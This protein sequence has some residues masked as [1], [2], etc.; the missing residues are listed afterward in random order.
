MSN[1]L[2]HLHWPTVAS[3]FR[4]RLP[5]QLFIF[6]LLWW[7]SVQVA[8][9]QPANDNP[10]GAVN[11]T[12]GAACTPTTGTNVAATTTTP[13]GYTNPGFCGAAA[14]PKDVW[15]RFTATTSAVRITVTGAPAG[16]VRLFSS[17]AGAAGPFTELD[18]NDGGTNNAVADAFTTAGLTVG[19]TY[20]VA[21]SGFGSNDTQGSFTICVTGPSNCAAAVTGAAFNTT[22]NIASFNAATGATGYSIF[23]SNSTTLVASGTITGTS[24]NLSSF[25]T[26]GTPYSLVVYTVCSNGGIS[27]PTTLN[28][29][30][31]GTSGT[32][33]AV[34]GASVGNI[35][36]NAALLTYTAAAG[37]TNYTITLS[38]GTGA[39][40]SGTLTGTSI[41]LTSLS[42]STQYTVTVV[43]NCSNG[44]T[45]SPVTV[46]F[47]TAAASPAPA[48]D[49]CAGAVLLTPSATCSPVNGTIAGATQ[50]LAAI[51]CGGSTTTAAVKDVWYRF[52]AT[53]ASHTV[54]IAGTFDG[55]LDVRTG[56][57][58]SSTNLDCADAVGNNETLTLTN[59]TPGTTYFLRYYPYD[60]APAG[61][62]FTI[63]VTTP[64]TAVCAD[65]TAGIGNVTNTTAQLLVTPGTGNTSYI[66]TYTPTGGSTTTLNPNPTTSP[67]NLVGLSPGT[68]YALTIQSVCANGSLGAILTGSFTTQTVAPPA[69]DNP[70]GAFSLPVTA[71]CTP[72]AGTNAGATTTT[73]NGF[74]NP[75]TCGVASAPR[76]VWYTFV[77]PNTSVGITVTGAPAGLVRVF[78]S[79]G[80]A[81][82]PFTQVS[83]GAGTTNN[84]SAG[85]FTVAGLTAGATYYVSV[86]GY[87]SNDTQ[88]AFT[89]CVTG[90]APAPTCNPVTGLSVNDI[91]TTTARVS[92][93]PG[94]G[95]TSYTI[96]YTPANGTATTVTSSTPSVN[97]STLTPGTVYTVSV[98]PI[99]AGG[100]TATATTTTFT[101]STPPCEPVS[102][103]TVSGTT[104]TTASVSFTPG[105]G[106]TS[107]TVTY[108]PQGGPTTTISPAPTA[109]P[110]PLSGLTP[111]TLYTVSV[112]PICAGGG[113]TIATTTTFTTTAAPATCNPVTNLAVGGITTTAA[114]VSFTPGTG[115]TSYTVTY[116]PA[117]GATTIIS[118][119]PT[120]SPV[121]LSNLTPG[122]LYTVSV[123]PICAGGG[124]AAAVTT[125]FTTLTPTCNPVTNLAVGGITTTTASVSFTPGTGN[126]S[127]T[128]TYTPAGGATT[129]ISPAPTGSPVA[130]SSLTP[131]TV[132]TV[133]VTPI[134]AGG[135]TATAVTTTFTT[136]AAPVCEPVTALAVGNITTTGAA[137]TFVPGTGNTGYTVTYTSPNGTAVTVNP[138]P[139]SSPVALTGLTPNTPYTVTVT[140][141]CAG[142]GTAATVTTTFTTLAPACDPVT[143]LT[144]TVLGST[145]ANL[146]FTAA[147]G[148]TS[149]TVTYTPAGG[150]AT[151]VT[152]TASPVA[153]AGLTP[154][155]SYTAT[156]TTTCGATQS[157]AA[158]VTFTTQP[159]ATRSALESQVQVFPNPAQRHFT[160]QVPTVTG[161]TTLSL[162]LYNSLGQLVRQQQV[163]LKANGTQADVDVSQLAAGVYTLRLQA[164][165]ELI[166]KRVTVATN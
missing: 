125:T 36:S 134:C 27:Q 139:T 2:L 10:A 129:T 11:L 132:Y 144:A 59:L 140:P 121:A 70:A 103:L 126:T 145:S 25:V 83:C 18:C 137:V 90:S 6:F 75:G 23:L 128:V 101:T 113:T 111:G 48:N 141:I 102:G 66:V 20:Y 68:T 97:L 44:G 159:L 94:T 143:N 13:N 92:F 37:A 82:G 153:L 119:A 106:N 71:T 14:N 130:L 47:T 107:Y 69:N 35:S 58:A 32:C 142:G 95:N 89:I 85:S 29:T 93:T 158:S 16:L 51:A 65:P 108:T 39:P 49:N 55:V 52:V 87:G 133:S 149:Y 98:T 43:T 124:T 64:T 157:S 31:A 116:T 41:S 42:P 56:T 91:F 84:T 53:A 73:P 99:C 163:S 24:V 155:T 4:G 138:T 104:T 136:T 15:Y 88:G 74:T 33:A 118:P 100:G 61:S 67:I 146:T 17:T 34:T 8:F 62:T 156:V 38:S 26:A 1:T 148:A 76:D 30:T 105:P 86:S 131:G 115:N 135:G 122:T 147:S 78:S 5:R 7:G 12:V 110:V 120:A 96:T 50:S 46:T 109:S 57:C 28:F 77:A 80:G 150:T 72:T 123:T 112:T 161:A 151:S 164:G 54:T 21:V 162:T 152:S 81:A 166:I 114:G 117:G 63:C 127:Y 165:N 3:Q 79:A 60:L 154:N 45:S 40:S 9:A 19:S 160:V 22:T